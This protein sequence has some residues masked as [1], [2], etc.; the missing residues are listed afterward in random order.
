[1]PDEGVAPSPDLVERLVDELAD[2]PEFLPVQLEPGH[3]YAVSTI[4]AP[5]FDPAGTVCLGLTLLG[6]GPGV[7]G[8]R[9]DEIGRHLRR[10]AD[11]V[12]EALA[13]GVVA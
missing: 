10:T 1:M 13:H 4:T 3:P 2:E 5:I 9:V 11:V 8:E 7:D 6:F 12:S